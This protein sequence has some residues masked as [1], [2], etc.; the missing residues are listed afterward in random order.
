MKSEPRIKRKESVA[1][2][3]LRLFV[4]SRWRAGEMRSPECHS[5]RAGLTERD[6]RCGHE[7]SGTQRKREKIT[8]LKQERDSE[9]RAKRGRPNKKR[10]S[11]AGTSAQLLLFERK[12][13]ILLHGDQK[14]KKNAKRVYQSNAGFA[15]IPS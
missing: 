11:I 2:T 13:A 3:L 7:T 15:S 4:S 8:H 6:E 12:L 1:A 14:S 5:S 10:R 9:R